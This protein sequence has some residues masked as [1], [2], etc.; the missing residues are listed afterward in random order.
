M[1]RRSFLWGALISKKKA[2]HFIQTNFLSNDPFPSSDDVLP[3]S[4]KQLFWT[5]SKG[6]GFTLLTEHKSL[7]EGKFCGEND[8]SV[9]ERMGGVLFLIFLEG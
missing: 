4:D 9:N 3:I 6:C 2:E 7:A 5:R 1:H 8:M